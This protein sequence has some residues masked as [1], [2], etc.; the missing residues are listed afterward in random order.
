[1]HHKYVPWVGCQA[2]TTILREAVL[3]SRGKADVDGANCTAR[4]VAV[5]VLGKADLYIALR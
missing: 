1:V 4:S 5:L 2:S 3:L